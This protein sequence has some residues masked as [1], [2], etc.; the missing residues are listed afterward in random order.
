MTIKYWTNFSKK[1]N[2]TKQPSGGTSLSVRLKE[3]TSIEA[4]VFVV[5]GN[6]FNVTYVQ[7]FGHYYFVSDIVSVDD[8]MCEI[9]CVQDVLATY[10]DDIYNY[11]GYVEYAAY[12]YND[13][14]M[15]N[16]CLMKSPHYQVP[17]IKQT[18]DFPNMSKT[19]SFVLTVLSSLADPSDFT[20][21]Y[22]VDEANL[23][24]LASELIDTDFDWDAIFK[25][26][27]NP[28]DAIVK[29]T[30]I[31]FTFTEMELQ[32]KTYICIGDHATQ[33]KGIQMNRSLTFDHSGSITLDI[34]WQYTDFRRLQP[35]SKLGLWI[36]F[37]GSIELPTAN[38]FN[39]DTVSIN[40]SV[41]LFT[42]DV[43]IYVGNTIDDYRQT[44]TY[45]T[46]VDCPVSQSFSNMNSVISD[47]T[48]VGISVLGAAGS[49]AAGNAVAGIGSSIT[50][51]TGVL[52]SILDSQKTIKSMK[53]SVNG[54]AMAFFPRQFLLWSEYYD[55]NDP[56]NYAFR[57]GRPVFQYSG[58]FT[59][60]GGFIQC[61][62][63]SISIN[64]KDSDR[65]EINAYLDNGFY[66]E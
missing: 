55:T 56:D 45:C 48:G 3:N 18:A 13:K 51:A 12:N 58:L 37:Y 60:E 20:T 38:F 35:Y 63:S 16:R 4:P 23:R 53:G 10:K 19:G 36:P 6:L 32:Y 33:A 52:N 28:I 46:G 47:L 2:S 17:G 21:T 14:I 66:L 65:T 40:Y 27:T 54:R 11:V 42:G 7:A 30:W 64:G 34:P 24:I 31:P 41:D 43:A 44:V 29:L 39:S 50:A 61:A 9:H 22:L 62:G 5:S 26:A 25:A 8:H 59:Y 49:F 15:D 1:K 57:V